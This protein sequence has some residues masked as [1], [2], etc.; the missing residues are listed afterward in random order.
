MKRGPATPD[1]LPHRLQAVCALLLLLAV[2]PVLA[3]A[4]LLIIL[5]SPGPVLFRQVRV[6]RGGRTFLL[7][8]LRTMRQGIG[9]PCVTASGDARI[10][11][12]GRWL[13]RRKIDELP[14]LWNVWRGDLALVGPR[15]EVPCY[16]DLQNPLWIEVLGARP[17]LTDP[18]TLWLRNEETL[19]NNV[20]HNREQFYREVLQ[21]LKLKGY[22][23]YLQTRN[24]QSDL[25][26]L[27]QTGRAI[28]QPAATPTPTFHD[29]VSRYS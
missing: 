22:A 19:L 23:D 5:S 1:G 15:P 8:K 20:P 3:G 21:P 10:T 18:V 26:I 16:V 6:G 14:Q 28:V 13:R 9:G 4:A 24:W 29:L 12:A 11:W 27:W 17:G 2:L 25:V 7:Y